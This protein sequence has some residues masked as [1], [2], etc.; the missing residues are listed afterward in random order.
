MIAKNKRCR[1]FAAAVKLAI[2]ISFFTVSAA[3]AEGRHVEISE[4]MFATHI[5]HIT[6]NCDDYLGRTIR[7]EGIFLRYDPN[8]PL[9]VV[10]RTLSDGCCVRKVGFEVKWPGGITRPYPADDSW[11]EAIGVLRRRGLL[12]LELNS[13]TVLNRRGAGIVRR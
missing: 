3:V 6:M 7:I 13:L 1:F 2:A 8:E 10:Y 4:R 12:Y 11:V 5:N 9:Y